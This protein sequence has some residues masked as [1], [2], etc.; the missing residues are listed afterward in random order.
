M[1]MKFYRCEV[2]RQIIAIVKKT[3]A[4]VVC[5]GKPMKE[6]IP[7]TS[8]GAVEKHV[9]AVTVDGNK[10]TV[11]VGSAPHPMT[12]AHYI[13]WVSLKTKV[14]NQRKALNP[15]DEPRVCFTMCDGDEV[16]AVY[17]Y[18]NLH[19]LWVCEEQK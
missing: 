1:E 3:G 17:A 4:P 19:G 16:E 15:G 2:C 14:G 12:E 5:C 9:P 8:D 13:E 7:G 6:L 11:S 10:V 18:C